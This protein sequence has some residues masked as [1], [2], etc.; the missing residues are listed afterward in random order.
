MLC[1]LLVYNQ[2]LCRLLAVIG[3]I[4]MQRPN[5][6]ALG[7]MCHESTENH[8]SNTTYRVLLLV[9]SLSATT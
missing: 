4:V 5:M 3:R 1:L 8:R 2:E 9:P 7:T 6:G